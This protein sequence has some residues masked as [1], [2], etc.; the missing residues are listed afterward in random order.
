MKKINQS[1]QKEL[2]PSKLFAGPFKKGKS[3]L[4]SGKKA[5]LSPEVFVL[6]SK[7]HGLGF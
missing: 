7:K 1:R 5:D 4:F 6:Y 3:G 2:A